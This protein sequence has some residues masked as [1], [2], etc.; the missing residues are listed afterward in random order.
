M[1]VRQQEA[2]APLPGRVFRPIAHGMEVGDGQHVGDIEGLGDIALALHFAH[3]Q[4][5]A[6]DAVCAFRKRGFIG[7][8]PGSSHGLSPTR[9]QWMSM[10]P[11]TSITAPVV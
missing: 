11:F 3:A 5:I 6:A 1:A 2:V 9:H 8:Q 7:S 4:R 10:P